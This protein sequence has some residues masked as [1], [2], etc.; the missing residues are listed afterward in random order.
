MSVVDIGA[1]S[2][3]FTLEVAKMPETR[4]VAIDANSGMLDYIAS[5]ADELGL[6]NIEC[7][8]TDS[9]PYSLQASSVDAVI[10]VHVF[11]EFDPEVRDAV[12]SEVSRI[13]VL[14]GRLLLI[15][16]PADPEVSGPPLGLRVDRSEADRIFGQSGLVPIMQLN[17]GSEFYGVVYQRQ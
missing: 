12:A 13:L 3:L 16:F 4:V 17:F 2:G 15:D 10:M 9:V 7:L 6:G 14:S 5:K 8:N 11:H 1:G